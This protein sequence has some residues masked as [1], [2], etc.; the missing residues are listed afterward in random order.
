MKLVEA[1]EVLRHEDQAMPVFRVGMVCGFNALHLQTF[2]R[3]QLRSALS[4]R[5]AEINVGLYTDFWGNLEKARD[6]G[7]DAVVVVM[8]WSDL[9][10]RL[11]LRSLGSWAPS[12]LA[13]ILNTVKAR[14]AQFGQAVERISKKSPVVVCFPT[15]PLPPISHT[16][17]WQAN[18]FELE[19]RN[20]VSSLSLETSKLCGVR[21]LNE[22]RLARL[23][24]F[25]QRLD[26]KAELMS[27]FP[28]GL[29]HASALA[30]MLTCLIQQPVA[31]KG[32]ITDLDDTLW[33]GILGEVGVD[34][35]SWDLEHQSHMHGAYQRF[36]YA[37][38]ESGVLIAVASKNN[39]EIVRQALQRTDLLLPG[40]TAFPVEV[41]WGP[42]SQSVSRILNTWNVGADSVVFI[43]DSP[44]EL[45]EV[46]AA[47]PEV[48]CIAFPKND[49]AAIDSLFYDL[50]DLFGKSTLSEEDAIRQKSIRNAHVNTS[51]DRNLREAPQA[52]LEQSEGEIVL[53]SCTEPLDP[54]ALELVNKTNQFNLNGKRH[55]EASWQNFIRQ[56]DAVFMLVA[57]SDKYGPLGK[58]AVL[59]G[60]R[61]QRRIL[62]DVWV[63][64]CRAFGRRIE[65][66]C[67]ERLFARPD[68][69]EVVLEFQA[70][71]KNGPLHD[72]LRDVMGT[73][74][75]SPCRL[76]RDQFTSHHFRNIHRI[77]EVAGG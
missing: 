45:A 61:E 12:A 53:T 50:R 26:V 13:D 59:A 77:S 35:V 39:P 8:E 37:L 11:G 68:V 23:S 40:E 65:H 47:H 49:Y 29:T 36:L 70:T 1:L 5:R 54:R 10:R 22:L 33:R 44:M 4:E 17:G 73:E 57:Y 2:L 28:Y 62:V 18:T 6:A 63:M 52:F 20:W 58:I 67:L 27:G 38:A 24:P 42:K 75:A 51:G 25:T 9:D 72:F 69:D 19:L 66:H 41:H 71:L 64:S 34:G 15:L 60:R 76:S 14:A 31:K 3:A 32:L 30:Q 55:T 21:V 46:K 48:E 56:S 43:D 7:S 16:A 74:P